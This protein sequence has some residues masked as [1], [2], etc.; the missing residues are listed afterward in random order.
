MSDTPASTTPATPTPPTPF[1]FK[2]LR[3]VTLPVL[4]MEGR[5]PKYLYFCGPMHQ[6]KS[7]DKDKGPATIAHAIDMQTGEEGVFICSTVTQRELSEQFPGDAYVGRGFEISHT[8][9]PD[10]RY[11]IVS[12]SEVSV[13]PEVERAGKAIMAA[14]VAA[15]KSNGA[16]KTPAKS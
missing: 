16:A 12:I 11:N 2:R 14:I 15:N 5:K 8:R 3:S 1:E 10:K 9:V 7:V 6:G 13:P 4:K